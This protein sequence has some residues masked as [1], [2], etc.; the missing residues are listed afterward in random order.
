MGRVLAR[1]MGHVLLA[2]CGCTLQARA[3]ALQPAG[4]LQP[5]RVKR[6][7]SA[8]AAIEGAE[9][10]GRGGMLRESRRAL[11]PSCRGPYT[12]PST[13]SI[14]TRASTV[15]AAGGFVKL[16]V[17]ARCHASAPSAKP[18]RLP[19]RQDG[20]EGALQQ[21]D[22]ADADADAESS[23]VTASRRPACSC[24]RTAWN[25]CSPR[26]GAVAGRLSVWNG[27]AVGNRFAS[28]EGD[29]LDGRTDGVPHTPHHTSA[30]L[31]PSTPLPLHTGA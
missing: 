12:S 10:E 8:V 26:T 25:V 6:S 17:L 24:A 20:G 14:S 18:T 1:H 11:R 15:S 30:S 13:H 21:A 27:W 22:R 4:A 29:L 5:G 23:S 2:P 7:A 9:R 28:V 31:L 19:D 3:R 16:A